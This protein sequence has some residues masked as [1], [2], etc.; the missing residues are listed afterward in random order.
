MADRA[1]SIVASYAP[2]RAN[3]NPWI[4]LLEG[5]VLLALGLFIVFMPGTARDVTRVLLGL[6]LLVM[7]VQ[8]IAQAFRSPRDPFMPFQMLRGGVG[9]TVGALVTM[10]P[11][12]GSMSSQAA[13]IM[14][15]LGLLVVG[16]IGLAGVLFTLSG[17]GVQIEAIITSALTIALGLILLFS[18]G[19]AS[20]TP[21][22]GIAAALG[23]VGL[24]I[25]GLMLM[26]SRKA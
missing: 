24:L 20:G 10:Q 16:L 3:A 17:D 18:K 19:S 15:G 14:L 11:L 5:I 1:K 6:L 8:Q 2:W 25:Y 21:M 7:S 13:W 9:A 4:V 22:L 26:R 23:G 12:F